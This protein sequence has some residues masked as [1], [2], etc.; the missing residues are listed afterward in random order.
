MSLGGR[1]RTVRKELGLSQ[2]ELAKI[3]GV[4]PNT[5]S[6]YELGKR[7]PDA[8]YLEKIFALGGDVAYILTG[9]RMQA[10]KL[11]PVEADLLDNFRECEEADQNAIRRLV[12][13]SA[14]AR[15]L[16]TR[17]RPGNPPEAQETQA[18]L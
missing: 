8:G 10:P 14:E 5:Q 9:F 15:R 11:S 12:T 6:I 7:M 1:L 2:G 17:A 18:A 16:R 4:I 13:R 3:T